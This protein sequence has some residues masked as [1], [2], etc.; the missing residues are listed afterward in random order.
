MPIPTVRIE[1]TWA[2]VPTAPALPAMVTVF[3]RESDVPA[4]LQRLRSFNGDVIGLGAQGRFVAFAQMATVEAPL[5]PFALD[6]AMLTHRGASL[7]DVLDTLL[8]DPAVIKV[9]QDATCFDRLEELMN[10]EHTTG[11]CL[12]GALLA[13]H[14]STY[15]GAEPF[16]VGDA[17][18]NANGS[19][20]PCDDADDAAFT[21]GEYAFQA[22]AE[23]LAARRLALA[24]RPESD[25][26]AL[27]SFLDAWD[28]RRLVDVEDTDQLRTALAR[29]AM[30]LRAGASGKAVPDRAVP[31]TGAE[32]VATSSQCKPS[33]PNVP[34]GAAM[35]SSM[36]AP[37][38][39]QPPGDGSGPGAPPAAG[40]AFRNAVPRAR[41]AEA[42]QAA[43]D[44]ASL[45]HLMSRV[46]FATR[47]R[48]G[49]WHNQRYCVLPSTSPEVGC[50]SG[51]RSA[52]DPVTHIGGRL[53]LSVDL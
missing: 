33:E 12:R 3:R 16:T 30:R 43:R 49:G 8:S 9:A 18:R 17:S 20:D 24:L 1:G 46:A 13:S 19:P 51:T 27:T 11:L 41:G 40:V 53:P 14:L 31:V 44:A 4:L 23:F 25:G 5:A 39:G 2:T 32:P 45:S 35:P 28:A 37:A 7:R 50:R 6:V 36:R 21:A 38:T 22:G 48:Y 42:T 47:H 10:E 26:P 29:R 52:T 15:V 34:G